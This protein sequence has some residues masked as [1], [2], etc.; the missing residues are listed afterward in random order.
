[1]AGEIS[2]IQMLL[3]VGVEVGVPG[4][5]SVGSA[6]R[7]TTL[8]GSISSI[9]VPVEAV[10]SSRFPDTSALSGWPELFFSLLVIINFAKERLKLR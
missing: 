7:Y 1:M 3:A 10:D 8:G 2:R 9:G 4:L 6:R 5:V